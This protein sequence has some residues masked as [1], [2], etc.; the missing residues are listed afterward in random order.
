MSEPLIV[1]IQNTGGAIIPNVKL[2]GAN[3]AYKLPPPFYQNF[4]L[5]VSITSNIQGVFN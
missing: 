3:I 4:G 2:F 5:T 1:Q